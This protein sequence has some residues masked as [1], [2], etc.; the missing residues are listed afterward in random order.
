M[1]SGKSGAGRRKEL[2]EAFCAA[3]VVVHCHLR[4][5]VVSLG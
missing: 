3:C 2:L 1:T 4:E 5:T